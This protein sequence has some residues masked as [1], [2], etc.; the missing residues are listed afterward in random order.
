MRRVANQPV[1]PLYV[2][3]WNV[4]VIAVMMLLL[5]RNPGAAGAVDRLIACPLVLL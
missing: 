2:A 3:R 5:V 1:V 4:Y